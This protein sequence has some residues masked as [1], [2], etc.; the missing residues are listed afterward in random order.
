MMLTTRNNLSRKNEEEEIEENFAI[1][2]EN[3]RN[4]VQKIGKLNN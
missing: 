4:V 1:T 3:K 2:S